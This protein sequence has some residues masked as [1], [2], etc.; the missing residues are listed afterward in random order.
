MS[1]RGVEK[2]SRKAVELCN[3]AVA[4]QT[5]GAEVQLGRYL[6]D[7]DEEI[8]NEE[9]AFACFQAAAQQHSAEGQ[10]YLATMLREGRGCPRD[11]ANARYWFESAAAQGYVPAYLPTAELY[12][13]APPDPKTGKLSADHLAKAYLWLRGT[14]ARSTD[15]E[16]LAR[17][18]AMLEQVQAVMPEAWT[19]SLD[20]K[21]A[22]HLEK[23]SNQETQKK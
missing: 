10:F 18:R 14:E 16:E 11:P 8:R 12:F 15:K 17:T 13:N 1:G 22:Q 3:Q 7:G 2:D 5:H 21:V 19:P 9:E 23:N 6:L 4:H 20:A